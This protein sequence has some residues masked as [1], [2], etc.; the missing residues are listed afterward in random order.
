MKILIAEDDATSR[1]VLERILTKCGYKVVVTC[2]GEEAW[3]ALQTENSPPLAILDNIM[4]GLE[5]IEICKRVRQKDSLAS[6]YLI[7]LTARGGKKEMVTGLEAG[8][9]DYIGKP[10]DADELLARIKVGERV[11]KLQKAFRP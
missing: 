2:D 1:L 8:A 11:V 9:D 7:L 4:P 10:F 3:K 6:K 5:G